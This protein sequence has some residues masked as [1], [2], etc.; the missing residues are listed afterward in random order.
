MNKQQAFHV[1]TVIA[2]E[3]KRSSGEKFWIA[4]SLTLLAM[5]VPGARSWLTD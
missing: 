5:T 2:S 3:A 1:R 4:S